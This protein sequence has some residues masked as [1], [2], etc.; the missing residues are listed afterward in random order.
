VADTSTKRAVIVVASVSAFVS[1]FMVS[2]TNVALPAIQSDFSMDAIL[3]AWV[4]ASYLLATAVFVLPF[5]RIADI[6]GRKTVFVAGVAIFTASSFLASV[7]T[8]SW[9]LLVARVLQGAGTGMI[10][11][12]GIAIIAS[13]F[14]AR[15]RGSAIGITVS[16]VY[17]GLSLGPFVGGILTQYV[18]WRSV[19]A[20]VVPV[21]L[22]ALYLSFR[23]LKG[24]WADARGES[25]D[26]LGSVIYGA[27]IVA[28]MHGFSCLPS[29]RSVWEIVAGVFLLGLF[30]WRQ[31]TARRP[32]FD[33]RLFT[34]NRT[35]ALS[36]LAALVNY[37]ATFAVTFML[38]LYLQYIRELS[39]HVAGLVLVTQPILMA[40]FSPLAGRLSDRIEPRKIA[41]FG[42]ALTAIG[43]F[44][45]TALDAR[46][47]IL[48]IILNLCLLGIGFGI[49]SSPN[50]NAIMSSVAKKSY[51]IAASGVAS[52]R[53]LGQMFSMGI[54]TLVLS[55]FVG[56]VEITPDRYPA[57][58]ESVTAAFL[59]FGILCVLGIFASLARGRLRS[60]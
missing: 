8:S 51:G 60:T 19:F 34:E 27:A 22:F 7:S 33:L 41:S 1:S 21:G 16:A 25:L 35:F 38:S 29:G 30:A 12:T 36:S 40:S 31:S 9:F 10:S 37:S 42:M 11:A 54:A 3:L 32:V 45:L 13:V 55:I 26:V 6:Y 14:P 49:F 57:F 50:M 58:L 2:A 52:M 46:T 59:I 17:I 53:L 48:Y 39:P 43:L 28:I 15:E 23:Y 47:T 24:Q 56:P 18:S 4:A 44:G 5:G 20:V